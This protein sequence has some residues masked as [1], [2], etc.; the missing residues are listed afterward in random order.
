[1]SLNGSAMAVASMGSGVAGARMADG[2]ETTG[3]RT[4]ATGRRADPHAT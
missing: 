4:C 1:M 2:L 3:A